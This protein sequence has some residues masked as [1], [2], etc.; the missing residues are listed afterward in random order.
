MEVKN[1]SDFLGSVLGESEKKT[2][3]ALDAAIG[4]VLV[5]DEAYG[6]YAK[7]MSDPYKVREVW[8]RYT[9]TARNGQK[10]AWLT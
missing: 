6:L 2:V 8:E 1:P 9:L 4:S 3:S 5:I 10:V 7:N